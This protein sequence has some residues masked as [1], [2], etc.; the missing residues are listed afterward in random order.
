MQAV[1][2]TA[3]KEQWVER[4]R[5]TWSSEQGSGGTFRNRRQPCAV[6]G[7]QARGSFQQVEL[8]RLSGAIEDSNGK[9]WRHK[10]PSQRDEH[11]TLGIRFSFFHPFWHPGPPMHLLFLKYH[12]LV[13]SNFPPSL[14]RYASL[15]PF[16]ETHCFLFCPSL[17]NCTI[18]GH[19]EC[20]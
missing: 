1:R 10:H 15:F 9:R 2:E 14:L 11:C 7:W 20:I 16:P 18:L 19:T 4:E 13:I 8:E 5:I 12:G 17:L 6:R 3:P